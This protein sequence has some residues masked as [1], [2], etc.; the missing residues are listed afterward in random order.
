METMR[1]RR[2]SHSALDTTTL[3][4]A[5]ILTVSTTRV[6]APHFISGSSSYFSAN[7]LTTGSFSAGVW[8]VSANIEIEPDIKPDTLN[9]GSNVQWITV[10][11][12]SEYDAHKIDVSTVRL[13]GVIP[14]V[15]DTQYSFV[16]SPLVDLNG[17]GNIDAFM[18]KFDR[19]SVIAHLAG[20]VDGASVTLTVS[21]EFSDGVRFTGADTLVFIR[22]G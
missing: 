9:L 10:Y 14:A 4:L 5:L 6:I 3:L 13:D 11:I 17:D 7:A 20:Y 2:K 16:T 1:W 8:E 19:A 15:T 18:V 12:Q 21:G 22:G